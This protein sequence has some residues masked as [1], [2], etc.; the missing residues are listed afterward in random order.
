MT[1]IKLYNT[2]TRSKETFTPIDPAN[3]RMY[4][5]GPTVY[6]RAHIG[7]ARPAVVFDLLYRLLRHIYS[8]ERV[9]HVRNLTDVDD[10]I[11]ARAVATKSADETLEAATRRITNE[12][13]GWYH[14][15]MDAIGVL[16]PEFEPRCT[17]YIAPMVSMARELIE[18]GHAYEAEGHVLFAVESYSDYGRLSGRSVDDMIAGA[19][20]EVA[21]YKKNPMDFV[22][23]KPST[24]EQPGWDSPWGRGRPGWH[25]EC[26]AMAEAILTRN[27]PPERKV[28]DIHAGGIDLAFPHHENELAQSCCAHGTDRMANW[29]MHNEMLRV[30]GEK[31]SKSLGNF[32][33]VRDLLDQGVTGEVIRFILLSAHYR[34]PLDWTQKRVEDAR[35]TL[36]KW[37]QETEGVTPSDPV[38]AALAAL[39][40]DLNT[41]GAIAAMH[42][43]A[44]SGDRQRLLA[45]MVLMGVQRTVVEERNA[46][47]EE[48]ALIEALLIDRAAARTAK[49]FARADAIRDGFAQAGI[50]IKDTPE[51]AVWELSPDAD[52]A[53]LE[54][55]R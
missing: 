11:I 50:V 29:W 48:R 2:A 26:S 8:A 54:A 22:I 21:P 35:V 28:F 23:W 33:T 45:T 43:A 34:Q 37:T 1:E 40:D 53:K 18:K 47:E 14:D 12:T 32:F 6:D 46:T 27:E 15:D 24:E 10:R 16:R 39:T 19:R 5:C 4:Q 30:E 36:R 25:I 52:P 7:N 44:R 51:G 17:E 20:V 42:E 13:I 31:M 55:L 9:T 38:P 41:A 3:V 49:D